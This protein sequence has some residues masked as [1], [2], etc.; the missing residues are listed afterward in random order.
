MS[1]PVKGGCFNAKKRR[2]RRLAKEKR[3]RGENKRI[4]GRKRLRRCAATGTAD[5]PLSQAAAPQVEKW[6][7]EVTIHLGIFPREDG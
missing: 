3:R 1:V 4:Y 7:P 5:L 6:R 2:A